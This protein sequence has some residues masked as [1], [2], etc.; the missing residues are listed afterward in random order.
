MFHLKLAKLKTK[1]IINSRSLTFDELYAPYDFFKHT[2]RFLKVD[3][4]AQSFDE[5]IV[6]E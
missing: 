1:E 4:L 3:I 5:M 2:H 6:W